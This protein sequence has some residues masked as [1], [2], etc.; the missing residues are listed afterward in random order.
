MLLGNILRTLFKGCIIATL[1][2]NG[3][4]YMPLNTT[5]RVQKSKAW[6]HKGGIF[7]ST[8]SPSGDKVV[9]INGATYK[10]AKKAAAEILRKRKG[11]VGS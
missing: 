1:K 6:R 3:R 11:R 10:N 5:Y 9:T 2:N 7:V 4:T 8:T